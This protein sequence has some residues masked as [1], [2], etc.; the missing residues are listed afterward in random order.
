MAQLVKHPPATRRPRFDFWVGKIPWRRNSLPTP[1]FIGFPGGSAGKESTCNE[2]DLGSTPRS[3]R[4][5]GGGD[6]S[7]RQYPCLGNPVDRGA[8]RATVH[9]VAFPDMHSLTHSAGIYWLPTL[10]KT[11]C[12][13]LHPAHRDV[14]SWGG[15][16]R[17]AHQ[18]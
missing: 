5:P 14:E 17:H 10:Y 11:A 18:V 6:G 2:G 8:W 15:K 1:V 7:P 12:M 4:A 13:E 16:T 3:R 9:G